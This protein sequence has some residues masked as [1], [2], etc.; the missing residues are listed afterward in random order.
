MDSIK[1][2]RPT[3]IIFNSLCEG[4]L[5]LLAT[6]WCFNTGVNLKDA[7]KPDVIPVGIGIFAG[8]ATAFSGFVSLF[9]A[10]KSDPKSKI[11]E[12][13]SLVYDH[14]APLF[15][16]LTVLDILL[17]AA[18]TGF[19]EE[20]FFRG[21]LQSELGI[22]F[23]AVLFGMIHCASLIMLPYA[24]WT[25]LAGIFLGYLYVWTDSLWTPIFAHGINNLIVILYFKLRK[26]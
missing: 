16:Q 3:F 2:D 1:V 13:R 17:I 6:L 25:F 15:A 5:L 14:V 20:I 22:V 18:S 23:A 10:G 12:L 21:V 7:L 26:P 4:G 19:C 8:A 24:I 9:L 11:Y